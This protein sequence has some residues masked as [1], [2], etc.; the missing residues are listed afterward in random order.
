MTRVSL[1]AA[2]ISLL[3]SMVLGTACLVAQGPLPGDAAMTRALQSAMGAAPGW[4]TFLTNTAKSPV[5]W[6]TLCV[7][8]GLMCARDNWGGAVIPPLALLIA[9][10]ADAL[11]RALIFAP[12]PSPELVS[13]AAASTASG[14]P[15]TFALVYGGLFGSV[16]FSQGK[17]SVI[18]VSA[19][20]LSTVFIIVGSC[21]RLVL[22][23]HWTSQ[24]VASFLLMFSFVILLN[25]ARQAWDQMQ[26][27]A[28]HR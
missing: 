12:K 25:L 27:P 9:Y 24:L 8:V 23:G 28:Q 15:S 2:S 19:V 22:G 21:A 11:L 6:I 20:I 1:A 18:S 14:L 7:A 5:V 17:R 13:V 3:L 4:A 10:L 26:A 16:I